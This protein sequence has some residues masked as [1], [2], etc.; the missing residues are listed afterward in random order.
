MIAGITLKILITPV[1]GFSEKIG[2]WVYK[3]IRK[4]DWCYFNNS[5]KYG[6]GFIFSLIKFYYSII[7][8][9]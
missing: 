9:P 8:L 2:Y 5:I 3:N 6:I 7:Y 1:I 4:E